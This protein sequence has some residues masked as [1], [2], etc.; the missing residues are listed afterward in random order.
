MGTGK[1]CVAVWGETLAFASDNFHDK[2]ATT[3]DNIKQ[4]VITDLRL[5]DNLRIYRGH[6]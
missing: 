6:H 5:C 1:K 2:N 4:S 3:L